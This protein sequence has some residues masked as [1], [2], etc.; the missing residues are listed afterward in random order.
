MSTDKQIQI[1]KIIKD[2]IVQ[3]YDFYQER[4]NKYNEKY[5]DEGL[6]ESAEEQL[7]T[8]I[9]REIL[10]ISRTKNDKT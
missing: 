1:N 7:R 4:L 3:G 10:Y 2:A 5:P 6:M 9:V 8:H